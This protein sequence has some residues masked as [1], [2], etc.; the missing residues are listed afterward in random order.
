M[1]RSLISKSVFDPV[2]KTLDTGISG[3]DVR[4]LYAII[5]QTTGDIL[6][7]TGLSNKGLDAVDGSIIMLQVDTSSMS[8]T[9]VIQILYEDFELIELTEGIFELINRLGFLSSVRGVASDLR[10]TPL[11]GT[12]NTVG[13]VNTV[14][15]V[16]NVSSIGGISA[17][18]HV[19]STQNNIAVLSNINNLAIT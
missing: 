5:N 3:F 13:T 7:A 19:P 10:V 4:N 17:N 6:Y 18:Q 9:D 1:K 11:G 15:A 16:S 14:S 12:I 2:S 8:S